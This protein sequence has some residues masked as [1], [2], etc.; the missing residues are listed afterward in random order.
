MALKDPW[1]HEETR[2]MKEF[3]ESKVH[4]ARWDLEDPRV[5]RVHPGTTVMQV[6]G[7]VKVPQVPRVLQDPWDVTGNSALLRI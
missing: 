1:V 3:V 2:V 5:Y 6:L 7:E 4:R